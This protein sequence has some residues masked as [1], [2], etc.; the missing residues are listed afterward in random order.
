RWK[1]V[2]DEAAAWFYNDLERH[3]VFLKEEWWDFTRTEKSLIDKSE[4]MSLLKDIF[5]VR[6]HVFISRACPE[7][8][9]QIENYVTNKKGE[10]HKDQKDDFIDNWRYFLQAA[11]FQ[12]FE[13]AE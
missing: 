10:Y 6:G 11:N 12:P 7:T 1:V 9:H 8:I 3:G 2:Y 5:S 4:Q 13:I